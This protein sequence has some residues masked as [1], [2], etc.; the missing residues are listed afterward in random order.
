PQ[1][2]LLLETAWEAVE[3]A[4]I[5]PTS[6]CGT[7]TGVY[8]GASASGYAT[9]LA[10]LPDGLAG[11][12]LTGT[13]ASVV[14]GRVS[15]TLG[16]RGPALTVDTAC[17]SS[18]VALHLAVRALR[19]GECDAAL[20]GG[21]TVMASPAGFVEFSRQGGL[22][23]DGRCKSF[24]AS[25]EGTGWSEGVGM[26]VLERL[27][28]ALAAGH[29]VMAVVRGSAV[30]AD[31]ASNG[32]TAPHGPAQEDVLRD[33]L[34][35]AG[36]APGEVDAVEAHGTGTVLGDP[37]EA[38]ALI[39]VYGRDRDPARPLWLGSLKS[40]IGHSQAAA[41][42]GG[43]IK[44]VQ[45]LRHR[46]LPATLHADPAT[47]HVDW[48]A[49]G[50]ALL[51]RAQP[52]PDGEHPRRAGVS[53]FGVSGTNAHIL[54]EQAPA[55]MDRPVDEPGTGPLPW[56]FAGRT[57]AGCRDSAAAL[58]DG[59][60]DSPARSADLAF[61][62]ATT[63]A[64]HE[65]RA[66]VIAA[67]AEGATRAL[68][69]A[70]DGGEHPDLVTG[71][72]GSGRTALL[73]SGQGSQRLGMGRALLQSSP[74]FAAAFDEVCALLDP[75]LDRPLRE[76]MLGTG[77]GAAELLERTGWAQ[78][79]LFATEVAL[80]ALVRAHGIVPDVVVGHSVGQIA[81]AHVAGVLVLPDACRLVVA[82]ARSMDQLPDGGAMIAVRAGE[83][84]VA[85]LLAGR[86]SELA[87]AAVNGPASVTVSGAAGAVA[88]VRARLEERGIRVTPLR[89]SH[90]FHS[91]L[92]DDAV[93]VVARAAATLTLREPVLPIVCDRR[94]RLAAP[95]E[96]TDPAHWAAQLREPVRFA[97]ALRAC[98][99]FGVTRWLEVGPD[100]TLTPLLAEV[101]EELSAHRR[102][103]AVSLL[104]RD[105][106][107]AD[108]VLRA[109][110]A[111]HVDGVD[112]DWAPAF[113][114]RDARVV[115][116][117]VTPLRRRR[118]WLEPGPARRAGV[119]GLGTTEHPLLAVVTTPASGGGT[120]LSGRLD[121][122]EHPWLGE[123][124]LNGSV[125]L[126][127]AAYLE[128]LVGAGD[129]VGC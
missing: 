5:D 94:G 9:D 27:D 55:E 36:L 117:P 32:L 28:D 73:F 20:V 22:A 26:L 106:D 71:S 84:V 58:R 17:S 100:A 126:P 123:H 19:A 13:A 33:A 85:E 103:P 16:L 52:W 95:G 125:V 101:L 77:E 119:P 40:N 43:V 89:V 120:V 8:V 45:A 80:A 24:G 69:A 99:T 97:D 63:R 91:P 81:A 49:G 29:R 47:E 53:A 118:Y 75:E 102:G 1:Q 11:Q 57:S 38:E 115:D 128:L 109:L 79:A 127:T 37:I 60:A 108:A 56:P 110:A 23:G 65:H 76:V 92:M 107:D 124:R 10:E 104:R 113:A 98:H 46:E 72:A 31:G 86:E 105:R 122:R 116:V 35:D 7:R 129:A 25:A 15:Y 112:V 67:D 41:G 54:L 61:S 18:L 64:A 70:V 114:G 87:I 82:R 59:L 2:R 121:P 83:D 88:E 34:R 96:L 68:R 51:N 42:V 93:D 21:V 66:V 48:S 78:P 50:V 4:G 30:N 90:A 111:L 3:R 12:L 44:M 62:L 6:L 74:V 39:A 14:S